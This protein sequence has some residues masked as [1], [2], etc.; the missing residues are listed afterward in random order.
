MN[1]LISLG[2]ELEDVLRLKTKLVAYKKLEK[3]EALND[4]K[5]VK[6]VDRPYTFCQLPA[7][8]RTYGWT[9]GARRTDEMNERCKNLCGLKNATKEG[10]WV[11]AAV[12]ATSWMPNHEESLKQQEDYPRMEAGEAIV[13]AP[14]TENKFDPDVVMI[15]GNVAQIMMLMCG[16]QKRKYENFDFS[17]LGEGDC[18]NSVARCHL[19]GKVCLTLGC[20]GERSMGEMD[21]GEIVLTLPPKE[22]ERAVLGLKDLAEI[23][24][25]YPI[26]MIGAGSDPFPE[27]AEFYPPDKVAEA[28]RKVTQ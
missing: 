16:L 4:I 26:R 14:L 27:L 12:M 9:V 22:L 15:Y 19:T 2:K 1:D 11:E 17:F 28:V 18:S 3:P 8:V 10:I 21:D 6:T 23:G 24:F 25:K 20:Y 7:M 5:D 13:M